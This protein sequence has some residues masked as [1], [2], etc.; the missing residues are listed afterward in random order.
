MEINHSYPIFDEMTIMHFTNY[1]TLGLFIKDQYFFALVVGIVWEIF[2]YS[3]TNNEHIE[4]L[5]VK[6][7]P[8]PKRLWEEK[9]FIN[10]AID[11]CSNMLGYYV[12]S[13]LHSKVHKFFHK[14]FSR[15]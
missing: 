4:R 5:L 9:N 12:G 14:T 8:V 10:R 6:Y 13:M 1:V 15:R 2:E 3:T 11:L 7:W